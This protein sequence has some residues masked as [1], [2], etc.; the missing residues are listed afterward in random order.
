MTEQLTD[1]YEID[2]QFFRNWWAAEYVRERSSLVAL[3]LGYR[4]TRT[5][6]TDELWDMADEAGA[7]GISV[8]A[9][10]SFRR[11][12]L[13]MEA[14]DADTDE[15]C[16]IAVEISFTVNGRDTER[17]IRNAGFL[18]RFTGRRA[19][20]VVSGM[21]KDDRVDPEIAAGNVVWYEIEDEDLETE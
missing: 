13:I 15:S 8:G 20:A 10:R 7:E 5:L 16:Y 14:V 21:R 17:A 3:D 1:Y 11:V 18:S 4:R 19:L 6:T 9:L 2:S 12:D